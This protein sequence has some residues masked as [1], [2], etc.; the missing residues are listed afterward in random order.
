MKN[1]QL[2]S[3]CAGVAIAAVLA[4]GT[5][6][7]AAQIVVDTSSASP[8]P[9]PAI[10]LPSDPA[11]Q[12]AAPTASP[13]VA[14]PTEPVEVETAAPA[15]R[16]APAKAETASPARAAPSARTAAP[17]APN[18]TATAPGSVAATPVVAETVAASTEPVSTAPPVQQSE[19]S[20][21]APVAAEPVDHTEL[22]AQI[23]AGGAGIALLLIGFM[24]L[25]RR[26]TDPAAVEHP[27]LAVDAP[28]AE[29][30][31][32]V[33]PAPIADPGF[34]AP[35]GDTLAV[36]G[37]LPNEGAAVALPRTAPTDPAEREALL[38][39]MTEARPDRANPFRSP[40]ARRRRARLILQSLSRKF[41]NATPRIDLSQYTSNW[42]AL[43]RRRHL[44]A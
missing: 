32:I 3:R 27:P 15:P 40:K 6:P 22:L 14:V 43:A 31:V 28:V 19:Q 34:F 4:L 1:T 21:T 37:G 33:E 8:A 41:E 10:V 35:R 39:K 16:P 11:P 29:E 13:T 26:R 5:T 38:Q 24:A 7:V 17:A 20:T 42:P 25:R 9:Q 12:R 23:L 2:H 30:P 18:A 36:A 44:M